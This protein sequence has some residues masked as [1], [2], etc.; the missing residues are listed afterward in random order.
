MVRSTHEVGDCSGRL[1][2]EQ[3]HRGD[4]RVHRHG[5]CHRDD[6]GVEHVGVAGH[7]DATTHEVSGDLDLMVVDVLAAMG[8]VAPKAGRGPS[9]GTGEGRTEP[10]VR[11]HEV[12]LAH[13]G[14][15]IVSGQRFTG[16]NAESGDV[17]CTVVRTP[18]APGGDVENP[19]EA[20]EIK[21]VRSECHDHTC[22]TACGERA[23]MFDGDGMNAC[24]DR[25][26]LQVR[27]LAQL[28]C[29]RSGARPTPIRGA[30]R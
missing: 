7:G 26:G 17:G 8:A 22:S 9:A 4:H 24:E 2:V 10:G 11:D 25:T 14:G 16:L 18:W 1:V 27:R 21:G 6:V 19:D 29:S 30:G 23:G 15:Q 5:R 28:L 12:S 20:S 13:G 3:D